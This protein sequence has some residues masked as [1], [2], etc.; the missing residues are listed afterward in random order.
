MEERIREQ[1]KIHGYGHL[2]DNSVFRLCHPIEFQ[3]DTR[4]LGTFGDY[5]KTWFSLPTRWTVAEETF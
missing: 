2:D 1:L 3:N 5:E 4:T